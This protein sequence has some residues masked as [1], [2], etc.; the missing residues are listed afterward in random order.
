MNNFLP[1]IISLSLSLSLSL[2]AHHFPSQPMEEENIH[3]R[4]YRHGMMD[5]KR[6][7]SPARKSSAKKSSQKPSA[8]KRRRK[9]LWDISADEKRRDLYIDAECR[10]RMLQEKIQQKHREAAARSSRPSIA[11]ASQALARRRK[12]KDFRQVFEH[13]ASHEGDRTLP[14]EVR[15]AG[16][17]SYVGLRAALVE[18]GVAS[19]QDDDT[20]QRLADKSVVSNVQQPPPSSRHNV[21]SFPRVLRRRALHAGWL[22]ALAWSLHPCCSKS[23][24]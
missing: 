7:E 24:E 17:M 11:P 3:D 21:H 13:H 14:L 12:E 8:Q 6:G 2:S 15:A 16:K 22:A 1:L 10:R 23:A 18:L 19:P 9:T 20:D 5:K 4:L